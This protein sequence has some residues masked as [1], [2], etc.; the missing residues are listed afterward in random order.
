MNIKMNITVNERYF[1]SPIIIW[2]KRNFKQKERKRE[3]N[4]RRVK[5]DKFRRK[6]K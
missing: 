6:Y 1:F 4:M 2:K 3:K 5:Y